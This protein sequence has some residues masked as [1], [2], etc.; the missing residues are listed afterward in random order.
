[1][2]ILGVDPGTRRTG[3]GLVELS[4]SRLRHVDNG[5]ISPERKAR[6]SEKVLHIYGNLLSLIDEHRP[7]AM[8]LEEVFVAKNT[9]SALVLGHARGA[10]LLAAAM[11]AIPIHG[12]APT[13]VKKAVSG[14]GHASKEQVQAMVRTLLGLPGDAQQDASDALALAICHSFFCNS[15]FQAGRTLT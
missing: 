14:S 12:Y 4:G 2:I 10:V 11:K 6:L 1:V 15:P 13:A 8:A 9:R 3:Y 5:V 7:A